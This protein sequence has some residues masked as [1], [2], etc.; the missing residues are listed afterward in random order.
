MTS[1][2]T[3]QGR[4]TREDAPLLEALSGSS[5]VGSLQFSTIDISK[6]SDI[7]VKFRRESYTSSFE[8]GDRVFDSENCMNGQHYL[9]WLKER[10]A[11][12][13]IGCVHANLKGTIVGQLESRIRSAELGYVNLF[14]LAPE[15]RGTSLRRVA[16]LVS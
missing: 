15:F 4:R 5:E 7:C 12:F 3:S 11:E 10:I 6:N 8:D 14:Y 1:P 9:S 2:L 16:L 13:P